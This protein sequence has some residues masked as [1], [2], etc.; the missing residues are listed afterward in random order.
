MKKVYFNS[1]EDA[2]SA[3]LLISATY[4]W[5]DSITT[6]WCEPIDDGDGWYILIDENNPTHIN[7]V[8]KFIP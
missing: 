4:E 3:D 2:E 5:S 8:S 6:R 1:K 7:V